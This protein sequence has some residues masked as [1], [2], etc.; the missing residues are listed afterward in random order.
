MK[1]S[2]KII[3]RCEECRDSG[4]SGFP[5]CSHKGN[6][7]YIVD[8]RID[9]KR[10]RETVG[11]N[12]SNAERRLAEIISQV[13]DGTFF[14]PRVL[15]TFNAFAEKWLNEY[16]KSRV[17]E[18]TFITYKGYVRGHLN[19]DFGK[20]NIAKIT[21]ED[22]ESLLARL[23]KTLS[24]STVNKILKVLKTMFKYARR[25]K[26]REDNPAWDID[27]YREEHAEMV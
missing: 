15:L 25:W 21:Q 9:G 5:P 8:Y 20:S 11:F 3:S 26:L 22:I 6:R 23:S 18:R 13:H 16:A 4:T 12:K 7:K 24:P 14:K 2:G 19:S 27:S 1:V 10:Y 17:K